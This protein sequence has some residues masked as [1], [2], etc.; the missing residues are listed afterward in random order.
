MKILYLED[1]AT[2][3]DL[4]TRKLA[5]AFKDCEIIHADTLSEARKRLKKDKQYDLALI[6]MHLPDGNGLEFLVELREKNINCAIIVLT[7]SGDEE[8]AVAALKSGADDYL[9]KK[10]NY[11]ES[12][13]S[14]ITLAI[15][16]FEQK[17]KIS[18]REIAVLYIEHN[19]SDIELTQR[20]FKSYA[21]NFLITAVINAE[22]ALKK[23][24]L[25]SDEPCKY[26]II[27]IDYR[28]SGINA[29]EFVK[30]IR[31]ERK[32][33]LA[34]VVVTGQG[35]EEIA[36]EALR[37]GVDEYLVKR[38]NY[39]FRLPSLLTSAYQYHELENKQFALEK[40]EALYRL[41]VN[42]STDVIVML[43]L[44]L[45]YTYISPAIYHLI[46][47]TPEEAINHKLEDVLTSE[48]LKLVIST[49]EE[50]IQSGQFV[51]NYLTDPV[52][53]ELE[54][55]RKDGS[56]VWTEVKA[57]LLFDEKGK[58]NGIFGVT[59]DITMRKKA[60]MD[61]IE[62][63]EK[64]EESDQLKTAFLNNISH[65]IRTPMNAIIGFSEFLNDPELSLESRMHFTDV[66]T[67]SCNQLLSIV[68]DIISIATIEAGQEKIHESQVNVNTVCESINDQF[69][70]QFQE[71]NISFHI[72]TPPSNNEVLINTDETKLIQV[73]TNLVGN[74]LKFTKKGHVNFG[75]E[76][77]DNNLEFFIE[78]TGIGIS[79]DMVEVIFDRFRQVESTSTREFG[80]SGLG[81]SISKAYANLFGGKIWLKSELGIGSTFYFSIPFKVTDDNYSSGKQKEIAINSNT[82]Q[83]LTILIA[84]D[85]EYNYMLFKA[86]L[87]DLNL[88]I[89]WAK[90][91]S[92]T[93][94]KCKSNP[95]IDL[96]LMDIKMPFLNG[97]E[98]TQQIRQFN[99]DI[100]II[101]QTAHALSGDREKAI[102]A[103]C[104][105]YISKPI[106]KTL[107]LR[108]LNKYLK[109]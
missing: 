54:M 76:I 80:G 11:L 99:K 13:P 67:K 8:S 91:G 55:I 105:E 2:D 103:G 28:L 78:D 109:Y 86:I 62:A 64:A 3:T 20:H 31:R 25:T 107:F 27:L 10:M 6:D 93:V 59:R 16:N 52:V 84:E 32:L 90:D 26:S 57:S 35:N 44:N 22:E 58:P 79:P 92:E 108:M 82:N 53:I 36:I 89:I 21:P 24:P 61:L 49:F 83:P 96:V 94:E 77:K 95:D 41:L 56:R 68:T 5:Q 45:T 43:D 7:G 69:F 71:K 50:E 66:I 37:L 88:N 14:S 81:L 87:K 33:A 15:K 19:K 65:E 70:P 104:N 73:L 48:S 106:D 18:S 29:L 72:T 74:A 63:K 75:Y 85:E 38:P 34:I 12:L 98:A 102:A 23:L 1:N 47:Y 39:L 101:A 100:I 4:T 9:T 51:T 17:R 40:S 60:L 46:G 97:Y 42:N 30:I